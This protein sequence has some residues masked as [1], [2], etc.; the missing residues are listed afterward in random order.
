MSNRLNFAAL[1]LCCK[2]LRQAAKQWEQNEHQSSFKRQLI[3]IVTCLCSVR[4]R[5]I[6]TVEV[7]SVK[8]LH[9]L[10]VDNSVSYMATLWKGGCS[11]MFGASSV[12]EEAL[13]SSFMSS[14][15][16]GCAVGPTESEIKHV[17]SGFRPLW[18][19]SFVRTVSGGTFH[20]AVAQ[21]FS[22]LFSFY[23]DE[24]GCVIIPTPFTATLM[25]HGCLPTVQWCVGEISA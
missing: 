1:N 5:W 18:A 15:S 23:C 6:W 21:V 3:H 20:L 24:I 2:D 7:I 12:W 10:L 14:H 16:S 19:C 8:T 13:T 4:L 11:S 22:R 9:G 25:R 17:G